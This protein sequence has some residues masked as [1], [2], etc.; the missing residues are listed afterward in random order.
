MNFKMTGRFLAQIIALEAV[1][2]VPSLILSLYD[3]EA[4][5]AGAVGISMGIMAVIA[6]V[7][8]LVCRRSAQQFSA[9][10]GMLCVSISWL[11]LSLLGCLPFWLSGQIP[12]FV[13]AFFEIVSGF[14]TTGASIL[15]DV[16]SLSRGLLYWRSFRPWLGG[17]GVLVFLLAIAPSDG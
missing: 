2:L 6:G 16:E 1:F 15:T 17:M 3:G 8:W 12:S 4:T 9:R 11:T 5:V 13:D 7:L 14:T 10:D